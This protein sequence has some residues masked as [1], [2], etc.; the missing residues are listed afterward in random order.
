VKPV[1]TSVPS[2][3]VYPNPSEDGIISI[4]IDNIGNTKKGSLRIINQ[5]SQT[6]KSVSL[7][8]LHDKAVYHIVIPS[9]G[10]YYIV[11]SLDGGGVITRKVIVE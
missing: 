4:E 3:N 9:A 10:I 1:V 8:D 11:I 6:V 2:V 5:L 7:C